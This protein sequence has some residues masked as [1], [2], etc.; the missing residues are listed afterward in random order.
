VARPE[1]QFV[2]VEREPVPGTCPECGSEALCRYSVVGEHGWEI[3]TKCQACLCSVAR[4]RWGRL[5][6]Y[7][8][9]VDSLP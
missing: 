7:S 4:E 1:T 2:S 6:P 9:L 3:V 8:L 5:G